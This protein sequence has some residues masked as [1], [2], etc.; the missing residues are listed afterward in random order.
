MRGAGTC[1]RRFALKNRAR[2]GAKSAAYVTK[3][4]ST[5]ITLVRRKCSHAHRVL[6]CVSKLGNQSPFIDQSFELTASDRPQMSWQF[7]S[8]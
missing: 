5:Q 2:R 4:V 3:L 6:A 8:L 7:I 1:Q